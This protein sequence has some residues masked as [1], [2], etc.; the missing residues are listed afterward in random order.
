LSFFEIGNV[1]KY[2]KRPGI[3]DWIVGMSPRVYLSIDEIK[4]Y[5]E[6]IFEQSHSQIY[7]ATEESLSEFVSL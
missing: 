3:P 7:A 2:K 1:W 4:R 5:N 6:M